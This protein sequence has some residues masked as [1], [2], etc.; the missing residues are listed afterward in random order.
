MNKFLKKSAS[1]IVK[2][3]LFLALWLAATY[4][5]DIPDERPSVWRLFAELVPMCAALLLTLFFWIIDEG[6]FRP[7]AFRKPPRNALVGIITG[8]VWTAVP[9]A[10]L[11]F[12]KTLA[13][14]G[15]NK[16]SKPAVWILACLC[17]VIMQELLVR[18]Y[19]FR[20]LEVKVNTPVAV[21]F[22][23]ALNTV[24]HIKSFSAGVLPVINA[25]LM[26]LMLTL[27]L[28]AT[29]SLAATVTAHFLWN[30]VGGIVT[31]TVILASD[32]PH[33]F[34]TVMS[35][36]NLLSGGERMLE[37]GIV[38]MSVTLAGCIVFLILTLVKNGKSRKK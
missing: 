27:M 34:N 24:L 37:G 3:I 36:K 5:V 16:V 10:V 23:V 33:I 6:S 18:G 8:V 14:E 9:L 30:L 21:F 13:F 19:M 32:Y 28:T 7:V 2:I 29:R 12:T 4:L 22:A 20:L 17:N 11:Y 35:G 31:G 1:V 38:P 26:S 25:V 15:S